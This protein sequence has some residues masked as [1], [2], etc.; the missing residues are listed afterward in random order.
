MEMRI[1][2][3][4]AF[5]RAAGDASRGKMSTLVELR[6]YKLHPSASN[7]YVNSF[8]DS[9]ALRERFYP[10]RTA[11]L[12]EVGGVL[13]VATHSYAWS[14]HEERNANR[15]ALAATPEW[16]EY[17]A[18]SGPCVMEQKSQLFVEPPLVKDFGLHGFANSSSPGSDEAN[19]DAIYEVRRYQLKLGY[20]TVP[21]WLELY[22][23]GLPSKLNAPGTDPTS[24]LVTVIYNEV[25]SL[26]EVIELWRHGAGTGA[27]ETSR[28]AARG[29]HEWRQAIA[30]I[31][32]LAITFH[33]TI[34]KPMA[35]SP[36]K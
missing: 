25:G 13:N 32:E 35:C 33:S 12:P 20:T 34:Q 10:L 15:A 17:L 28:Q 6:E 1:R 21:K 8:N 26:N 5:Y 4:G 30:N 9:L 27:M 18:V 23:A 29:A 31:A 3:S 24:S 19:P 36:W 7:S 22:S 14:G 2:G 16:K 11:T